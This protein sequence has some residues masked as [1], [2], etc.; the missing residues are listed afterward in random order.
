VRSLARCAGGGALTAPRRIAA[1]TAFLAALVG[2]GAAAGDPLEWV[3]TFDGGTGRDEAAEAVATDAWGNLF[4]AGWM[5]RSDV[6][7]GLDILVQSYA[8]DG[9]LRWSRTHGGVP[10]G[11]DV[12]FGVATD[13]AGNVYVAGTVS[14]TG[15]ASD[16]WLRKYAPDGS[17][18]WTETHD[19]P[20]SGPPAD[21]PDVFFAVAVDPLSGSV[22]VVGSEFRGDL[23]Q[24]GNWVV[25]RYGP[26]GGPPDRIFEGGGPLWDE[27]LGV[28]VA[29]DGDVLVAG[30]ETLN[31]DAGRLTGSVLARRV[32]L[33]DGQVGLLDTQAVVRRLPPSGGSPRWTARYDSESN[34]SV[35]TEFRKDV[36]WAVSVGRDGRV[37]AAGPVGDPA[38]EKAVRRWARAWSPDG[39]KVEWT[40][41]IVLDPRR[42]NPAFGITPGTE[43]RVYLAGASRLPEM[44]GG[45]DATLDVLDAAAG[46]TVLETRYNVGFGLDEIARAVSVAPDGSYVLAGWQRRQDLG[47]GRNLLLLKYAAPRPPASAA[48]DRPRAWPS[49]FDPARAHGGTLKIGG[50]PPGARVRVFTLAGLEVGSVRAGGTGVAEWDGRTRD[51]S[52][53]AAGAYW[54]VADAGGTLLGRGAFALVRR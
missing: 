40:R 6:S 41:W 3:R 17:V 45:Y 16:G 33:A 14:T 20:G 4:V 32:A 37:Y 1:L 44:T 18:L 52:P 23:V 34:K 29:P 36:A 51:G 38:N 48:P 35:S 9:R 31:D 11:L 27:A 39:S 13:S 26:N 53:A 5:D 47:Q 24:S 54:W 43:G 46:I 8:P 42:E 28:A 25:L 15:G 50:L 49:P 21:E 7:Q 12:A 10:G 22:Y 30:Y 19:G 2:P